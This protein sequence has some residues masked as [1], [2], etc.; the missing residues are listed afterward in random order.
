MTKTAERTVELTLPMI[1]DVEIAAAHAAAELAR[2]LGMSSDKIDEMSHAII[3]ACINA[4]E[5]SCCADQRI[6]LRFVGI[7]EGSD[8]PRVEVWITDHGH[9]FDPE[10]A[11]RR[12]AKANSFSPKKRGWGLQIM[13]AY[14]DEVEILSGHEG[15]TVRMLK[16]GADNND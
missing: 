3:E 13:E 8:S 5:H 4:R 11:K 15:T 9:G 6:Y 7:A 10:E 12:R 1:P 2:E 14:M 16:R